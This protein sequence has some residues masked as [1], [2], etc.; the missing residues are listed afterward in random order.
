MEQKTVNVYD[1][2]EENKRLAKCLEE[3]MDTIEDL[4]MQLVQFRRPNIRDFMRHKV[5]SRG[6][7]RDEN[8]N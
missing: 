1:I 3:A 8:L 2:L 4:A 5:A 7:N 6:I